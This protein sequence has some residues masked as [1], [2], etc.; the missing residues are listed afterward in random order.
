MVLEISFRISD[1][2]IKKL[3]NEFIIWL[4]GLCSTMSKQAIQ[5]HSTKLGAETRQLSYIPHQY[6]LEAAAIQVSQLTYPWDITESKGGTVCV[7]LK[8]SPSLS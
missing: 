2:S 8:S 7:D 5:I 1:H 4:P 3:I 6:Q